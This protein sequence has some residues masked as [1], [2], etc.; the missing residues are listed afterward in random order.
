M[1]PMS[2]VTTMSPQIYD[3][4]HRGKPKILL[5]SLFSFLNNHAMHVSVTI[6][7]KRVK[8]ND[9]EYNIKFYFA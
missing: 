5:K 6:M 1:S 2:I 3:K 9:H 8:A 7:P 4:I